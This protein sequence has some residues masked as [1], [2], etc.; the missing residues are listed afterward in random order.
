MGFE[1]LRQFSAIY[2]SKASGTSL[3]RKNKN[4]VSVD[5]QL[6]A[7]LKEASVKENRPMNQIIGDALTAYFEQQ[8]K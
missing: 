5:D 3:V 2:Q 4:R 8:Q 7:Q 1:A 6:F